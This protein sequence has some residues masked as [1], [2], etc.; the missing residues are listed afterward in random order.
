MHPC[1]IE[2]FDLLAPMVDRQDHGPIRRGWTS[3]I[4]KHDRLLR[5]YCLTT[6]VK[7]RSSVIDIAAEQAADPSP[8]A[9]AAR[10]RV[11]GRM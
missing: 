7:R 9:L 10:C 1:A 2:F 11:T 8:S 6:G 5:H 3:D 4:P